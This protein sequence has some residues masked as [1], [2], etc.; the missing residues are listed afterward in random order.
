MEPLLGAQGL[1]QSRWGKNE[2]GETRDINESV[3]AELD[4]EQRWDQGIGAGGS[5]GD[6]NKSDVGSERSVF[7]WR[8]EDDVLASRAAGVSEDFFLTPTTEA[9][10]QKAAKRSAK[11]ARQALPE[12]VIPGKVPT[13]SWRFVDVSAV[14]IRQEHQVLTEMKRRARSSEKNMRLRNKKKGIFE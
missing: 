5:F 9:Q 4:E 10:A 2:R 6:R 13:T 12:K 1:V 3:V 11:A 8:A 7:E 14:G